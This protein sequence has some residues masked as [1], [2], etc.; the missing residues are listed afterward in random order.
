MQNSGT[1]SMPLFQLRLLRRLPAV[2][3]MTFATSVQAAPIDV[4][5]PVAFARLPLAQQEA[6]RADINR[7]MTAATPQERSQF[8]N[9]VRQS[10]EKLT[11]E[12]RREIEDQARQRW[13]QLS[14][15]ERER[16]VQQRREWVEKMS[17]E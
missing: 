14:P 13:Q 12:Q 11:P 15:Q 16:L 6:I 3:L 9:A 5:D 10:I 7:Q 4:P 17:P 2:L 1:M 8:R